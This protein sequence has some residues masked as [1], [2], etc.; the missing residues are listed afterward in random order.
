MTYILYPFAWLLR[1]LYELF[2]SY[3]LALIFFALVIKVILLYFSAKSKKGMMKTSRLQPKIKE[4]EKRYAGNKEKYNEEL[5]KLYK[6]NDVKMMSGCIWS[7][8][9][10]P[11]LLALYNV[12]RQPLTYMMHLSQDQIRTVSDVITKLGYGAVDLKGAYSEIALAQRIFE[13][14]DAV[15]AVVPN[16]MRLDFTFLGLNMAAVPDYKFIFG[17]FSLEAFGLFLIPIISAVLA[18]VSTKVSM[19]GSGSKEQETMKG[20][21]LMAPL[22]SLWIGFIMPA[23]L[24]VY[25]I[26]T[27]VFQMI[28]D[29]FLGRYYSKVLDKEDAARIE[30]QRALEE[31]RERKRIEYERLKA[32]NANQRNKNTSKKKV[33]AVERLE[34]ERKEAEY[35]KKKLAEKGIASPEKKPDDDRPF[36]RGRAYDP[37]RYAEV[38]KLTREKEEISSG[39]NA[40]K[41]AE[42]AAEEAERKD[43]EAFERFLA[44]GKIDDDSEDDAEDTASDNILSDGEASD[45]PADKK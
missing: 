44:T 32:E 5:Q 26:A 8:I 14:F 22:M 7:L 21:T 15:K 29:F 38:Q 39:E 16:V 34:A 6:E 27:S 13:N 1:V 20:M 41:S 33:Q 36:A 45:G 3:G 4:L 35:E 31:E 40:E 25:W 10:L 2:N 28:Q 17:N 30:R 42:A 24:G 37:S 18:W 9:P 11:I 12:I 23:G 43:K 19:I